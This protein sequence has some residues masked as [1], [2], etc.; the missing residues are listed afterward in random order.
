MRQ[1]PHLE[2]AQ[3]FPEANSQRNSLLGSTHQT[4]MP[5]MA[6]LCRVQADGGVE[7]D[8]FVTLASSESDLRQSVCASFFQTTTCK[9]F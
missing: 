5:E 7:V 3:N 4:I 6:P 9:I 1:N 2:A 8:A